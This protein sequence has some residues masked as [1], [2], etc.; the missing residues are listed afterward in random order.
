MVITFKKSYS[1]LIIILKNHK[2]K[3]MNEKNYL[4]S[5]RSL[6]CLAGIE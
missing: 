4:I 2:N 6:G 1:H 5:D 3:E